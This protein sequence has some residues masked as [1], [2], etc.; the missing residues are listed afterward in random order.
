MDYETSINLYTSDNVH[1]Y[2]TSELSCYLNPIMTNLTCMSEK[3][4]VGHVL[5]VVTKELSVQ[6]G[7]NLLCNTKNTKFYHKFAIQKFFF[8]NC[9]SLF[10]TN[11]SPSGLQ[12]F[13]TL[14]TQCKVSKTFFEDSPAEYLF[15]RHQME[16]CNTSAQ[17]NV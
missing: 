8:E 17:S 1:L 5:F 15:I 14:S 13:S 7:N 2:I 9:C 3:V 4:F 6:W 11:F 12:N 16:Y 10:A